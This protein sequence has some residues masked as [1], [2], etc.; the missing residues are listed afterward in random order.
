[1]P[2]F[3]AR[4]HARLLRRVTLVLVGVLAVLFGPASA[5]FAGAAP[6]GP[7]PSGP[8]GYSRLAAAWEEWLLQQPKAT[9][10]G[11]D[12]TGASCGV[13]QHG[14]VWFLA[15][16]PGTG[17]PVTRNCV[18][19]SSKPLFFPVVNAFSCALPTDPPDQHTVAYQRS[20]VAHVKGD[21]HALAAHVDGKALPQGAITFTR[22]DVFAVDLPPGNLFG[23]PPAVCRPGVDSGYYVRLPALTAGMHTVRWHGVLDGPQPSDRTVQDVTYHLRVLPALAG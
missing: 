14:D 4:S 11:E 1:M 5:A 7:P 10:P 19:P 18:V 6:A 8:T 21:S 13:G 2:V 22:S 16:V 23:V 9:N 12:T 20:V 17:Q 3:R 15:G